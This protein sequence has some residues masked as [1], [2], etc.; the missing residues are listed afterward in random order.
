M[1]RAD[2]G[3][4]TPSD[5]IGRTVMMAD[6]QGAA[7]LR[8]MLVREGIDPG[9]VRVIPHSW[10]LDDLVEG[11]V[12]AVSAYATV[13]PFMMQTRGVE[14][15]LLRTVDYGVDFYGDTI[16]ATEAYANRHPEKVAALL[17]A[18]RKGWTYA[19]AN[20]DETIN[21][22]LAMPTVRE[23]P[24]SRGQL[25]AEAAA[26][27]S[28][29]LPDF[30]EIGHINRDRWTHIAEVL[31]EHGNAPAEYSLDGFLFEP[32]PPGSALS[33]R[34]LAGAGALVA[35]A[36]GFV[37]LWNFQMRRRVRE[38]TAALAAEIAQRRQAEEKLRE[39][40]AL[41]E[42][43]HD[44]IGVRSL[45]HRI[46]YW[47]RGAEHLYGWTATEAKGR[48]LRELLDLDA[49]VFAEAEQI[50]K[51]EGRWS[52]E[53]VA[54]TRGAHRITVLASWTLMRDDQGAPRSI[55][56]IDTDVTE[57]KQLESQFLRAQRLESLGT[58]AGGIAHDL[59]NLLAPIVM[60]VD[61]LR[62]GAR[63]ESSRMVL[64]NIERS[65][66]RGT[67]L[68]KQVLSFARGVEG[69]RVSVNLRHI[70]RDTEG[71]VESTFPKNIRFEASVPRDLWLVVC[72]P[73]QLSQVLLNL[74]VN[75]R[76]AMPGGGVLTVSACN[77][78]IDE[79]FASMR[80]GVTAGPY[81]RV[82]VRDTGTGIPPDVL[83]RIFDPFFTTKEPGKGTGL[84]LSTVLGIVRN[85]G[86]FVDVESKIGAGT[87]FK[88]YFPAQAEEA[89]EPGSAS[90]FAS[91]ARGRGECVL[92]VDDEASILEITRQTLEA[93]GYRVLTAE[94][95]AQATALFASHRDEVAVV[96]TDMMMPVMDGPS[97]IAALRGIEPKVRIVAASGYNAQEN[98]IRARN[99][100]VEHFLAKPFTAET[101]LTLLRRV[102]GEHSSR[103][104]LR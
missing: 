15:A 98:V 32:R 57:R 95:G 60:G 75:A 37:V 27:R 26:M 35:L 43:A 3:I 22:I 67:E 50:L 19:F 99:L 30:V 8:A 87:A 11:R 24:L 29:V 81:V 45:D 17:R 52:G 59:N 49:G 63:D 47:N 85:H 14:P 92:V 23:A 42:V 96:I 101:L 66:M 71:I 1:S 61:L 79:Q 33:W 76:D 39:Q 51:E 55:L 77:E 5:L 91:P 38:R 83:G 10:N 78:R 64:R 72:D 31:A 70:V 16:F 62:D 103:S 28:L 34:W 102:L 69:A 58:L 36:V 80:P 73:T 41:L 53:F 93:F 54:K 48:D 4:R 46:E 44:G 56:S 82:D 6:D 89:A 2:R 40:A 12:D 84:G 104:P 88:V 90:P 86:G 7:Q 74:A 20:P 21:Y 65:A 97:L 9:L 25:V 100:G 94:D 13:E 68:V 18:I